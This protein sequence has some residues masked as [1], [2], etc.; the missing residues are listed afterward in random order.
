MRKAQILKLDKNI[1][2]DVVE[3]IDLVLDLF[4]TKSPVEL[5]INFEKEIKRNI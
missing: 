2:F 5:K 1:T 4:E 3:D